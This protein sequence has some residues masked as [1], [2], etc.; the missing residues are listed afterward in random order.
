MKATLK[1]G[2][3]VEEYIL[4]IYSRMITRA[5]VILEVCLLKGDLQKMSYSVSYKLIYL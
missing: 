4:Q 2:S 3:A 5:E 1:L